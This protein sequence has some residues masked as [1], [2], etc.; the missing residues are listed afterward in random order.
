MDTESRALRPT[1]HWSASDLFACAQ[2][3]DVLTIDIPIGLPEAGPRAVDLEARRLLGPI[4]ASSV[5]PAPVRATLGAESWERACALSEAACGKRLS[6]QT[7]AILERIRDVDTALRADAALRTRVREIHP[8]LCFF[9]MNGQVPVVPPKRT[10]E[11]FRIRRDLV[12]GHFGPVFEPLRRAVPSSAAADDDI[13]DAVA[14][15]W[16]AERIV[17][18]RAITIPAHPPRDQHGLAMQMVA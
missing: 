17:E 5:F 9:H 6:K 4:R 18:G 12:E 2:T 8:E 16:T 10:P 3:L 7:F 15:L 13:L 1:I 11:G 14:A